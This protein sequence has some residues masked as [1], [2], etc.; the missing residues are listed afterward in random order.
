MDA[1]HYWELN[2]DQRKEAWTNDLAPFGYCGEEVVSPHRQPRP[3]SSDVF[4]M[5]VIQCD[6]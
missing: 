3:I 1:R 2:I 5:K 6:R 4:P